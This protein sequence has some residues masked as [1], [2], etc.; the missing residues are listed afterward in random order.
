MCIRDS[1]HLGHTDGLGLF[2]REVMGSS[3]IILHCSSSMGILLES[4]PSWSV[5][6][7]QG[8]IIPNYWTPLEP[9][10]PTPGCGFTLT[11]IPVP[12]RSELSDNHA[13][14]IRGDKKSLLFM[15]DQDSWQETLGDD[16]VLLG[17]LEG[18]EVDGALIDG[19]FSNYD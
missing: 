16:L 12:H 9:F 18:E 13:L 7:E 6:I 14:I 5:M 19:T 2:G 11:A 17:W 4:T 3:G 10:E 15:P 8:V 1:A